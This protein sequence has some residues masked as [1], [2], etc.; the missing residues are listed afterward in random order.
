ML[1]LPDTPPYAKIWKPAAA[2]PFLSQLSDLR[3]AINEL[4]ISSYNDAVRLASHLEEYLEGIFHLISRTQD[5][6]KLI[7]VATFSLALV[8]SNEIPWEYVVSSAPKKHDLKIRKKPEVCSWNL[9]CEIQT[10]VLSIGFAYIK[11]GADVNN[12]LIGL[13]SLAELD[14]KW[15]MVTNF[16]KKAM[17]MTAFGSE[18][19]RYTS[20]PQLDPRLFLLLDSVANI[21]LQTSILG[22]FSSVQRHMYNDQDKLSDDNNATL[23]RVSIWALDEIKKCQRLVAEMLHPTFDLFGLKT[24]KWNHYLSLVARYTSAYAGFFLSIEYY[25]KDA[26]G[27]ALGLVNFSLLAL[28]SKNLPGERDGNKLISKVKDK[29][30]GR[31]NEN[32]ISSLQSTTTLAIDKSSFRALL[33]VVLKDLALLFDML[34]QC[35]LKYTKENDN[36]RFDSVVK[37]QDIHADSKWPLGSKIPVSKV[38]AYC[39]Q[40]LKQDTFDSY[41]LDYPGRVN[42][43]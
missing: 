24:D 7:D 4:P 31:E 30:T 25:Q 17:A 29:L 3:S 6:T 34:V 21:G 20:I 1:V 18:L 12:E 11:L 26:L 13:D 16:Y 5:L 27:T 41:K 8:I 33:G 9:G 15:K 37:W 42:Y 28:Q 19:S 43:Y 35:R 36:L 22:K 39:P 40:S 10:V 32:Y 2:T 14:E 23:C 38:E